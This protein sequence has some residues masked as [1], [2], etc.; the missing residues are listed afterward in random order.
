MANEEWVVIDSKHCDL[1]DLDVELRE[2]RVY[3]TVD[4]LNTVG[5]EK[6]VLACT[7]S[8]A[9]ECNMANIPCQWAFISPGN[10][11]F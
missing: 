7:C 1:I 5:N 9:I 11:R 6:R 2:R 8:A 3:P 10:D 4:F